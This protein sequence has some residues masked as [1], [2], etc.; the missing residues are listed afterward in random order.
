M[1]FGN[2]KTSEKVEKGKVLISEPFLDDPNFERTVVFVC[3]H[4]DDGTFG[5]VL[6]KPVDQILLQDVVEGVENEKIEVYLGGPVEQDV[7]QFLHSIESLPGSI[8]VSDDLFLGGDFEML[9]LL[10]N[11]KNIGVDDIKFFIGYS[12]WGEGQLED[13]LKE[14]V[15]IVT[16]IGTND[17][18]KTEAKVLWSSVLKRMGGKYKVISNFPTDPRLN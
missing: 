2:Y 13:E 14:G 15:W 8:R 5:L 11:N 4:N 6:N 9:K 12:G 10:I 16:P 7:L 18:L 17:V 3:E 1:K